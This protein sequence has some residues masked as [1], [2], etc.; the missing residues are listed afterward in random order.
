ME[1]EFFVTPGEDDDW[2]KR[3]VEERLMWWVDQ[4]IPK[5]KLELLNVTGDDLAHYSKSTVT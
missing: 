5:D 2:H 1:L 3:W 4:G